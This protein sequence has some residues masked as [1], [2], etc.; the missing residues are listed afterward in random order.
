MSSVQMLLLRTLIA[1]FWDQPYAHE[2]VRWGTELHD[3]F[4]LPHYVER[5]LADVVDDLR[6]NDYAFEMA[7]FAPFIEFRFPRY[8]TINVDD[9][10]LEL[11]FAIEPW[12]VLGEEVTAQGTARFV[13]SSVERLQVKASGLT[14]ERHAIACNG[15]RLPLRN[16]GTRGEYVAGVRFKAWQPPSGLHPTIGAHSPLVFDVVD[17]WNERSLGGCTYHVSH[18]GGRHYE[19]FPVNANEAEARRLSRFAEHGHTGGRLVLA[20]EPQNPDFPWTLDL[21]S[22]PSEGDLA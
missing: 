5:D 22:T 18:P 2:L 12:N 6:R 15:R 8:G 16:T 11:R 10:E 20:D 3:R 9:L 4:M 14:P 21:R 13:D 17:T 19:T 7:W 1:R